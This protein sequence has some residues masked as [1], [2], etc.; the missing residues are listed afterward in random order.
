MKI[1]IEAQRIFRR[2]KHG[3]DFVIL[4]VL[5]ELQAIDLA[6][7]YYVFVA[8]GEDV[9]L[10]STERM[11]VI[12][13]KCPTYPLWEQWALPH[14]ARRYGVDLLHCTSNTAPLFHAMPL[15]LTLHDIIFLEPRQHGSKSW[16][17]EMGWYYR[18]LVVPRILPH[19]QRII[20]VSQFERERIIQA[21]HLPAGK[22]T[23]V[24][25][26]YNTHFR[27]LPHTDQDTLRRYIPTDD[28]LFFLGNTDPKKN[29]GR[30]LQAYAL[31]LEKSA[32]KRPL[33]IADLKEAHI[34]DLLRR[35][36]IGHIKP[37]LWFPG[38]IANA[39]LV[40]IYNAC[41]AFLYPSLRESFGIPLLEAM[42]CGRP[43]ITSNLSALPEIAGPDA[44][45]VD[46]YRPEEIAERLLMLEADKQY[47]RA[48]QA[49]GLERVSRFTWRQTAEQYLELYRQMLPAP[50][51]TDNSK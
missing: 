7:E 16:Y 17:Q 19:C 35:N 25:N 22:V 50:A 48:Q 15:V 24:H 46:P 44:I 21:L 9:C 36:G 6:N 12:P 49:Y 10:E 37:H 26:G 51:H 13:L 4:E 5:R 29:A 1:G 33:L 34:D 32:A 3:M 41:F 18:R 38:Y 27:L 28:F 31:Y 23:A 8:P 14:A 45:L 47:Y 39:D 30:V 2:D 42:A 20:T 40:S 43:V 11:H